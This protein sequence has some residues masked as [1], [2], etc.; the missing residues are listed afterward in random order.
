MA[1]GNEGNGKRV[2]ITGGARGIGYGLAAAFMDRGASV[3][4]SG[5]TRSTIDEAVASLRRVADPGAASS[6][7]D[8]TQSGTGRIFG[9]P[10]DVT[11]YDQV[12]ALWNFGRDTLGGVDI[13]INNAGLGQAQGDLETLPVDLI[14]S[15]IQVNCTGALYGCRVAL[16]GMKAQ[17]HGAIYNLEGLGSQGTKIRGMAVYGA[18]KRALAYITDSLAMETKDTPIIVGSL[19][20]GMTV[21]DL[22]TAEYRD[23]PEEWAKVERIFNI[24]SDRVETVAPW[25]VRKMLANRKNGA[26]FNWLTTRKVLSRFLSAP[27]I[28]RAV[29]KEEEKPSRS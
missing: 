19:L 18:S 14:S 21:T 3:V 22:I 5:R 23:K 11:S 29:F 26:R 2:V 9:T 6:T 13:W 17:G 8:R 1:L 12:Q 27:F 10:C 4:I 16:K 25:L 15:I 28:T 20:P 7:A 24:L